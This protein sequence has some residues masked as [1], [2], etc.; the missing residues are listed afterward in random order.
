MSEMFKGCDHFKGST[1]G[2]WNVCNVTNMK[3]MF[4]GCTNFIGINEKMI[5]PHSHN[6]YLN[7][8]N[9]NNWNVCKVMNME[10][11]FKDCKNFTTSIYNWGHRFTRKGKT[12]ITIDDIDVNGNSV[13]NIL[14]KKQMLNIKDIFEGCPLKKYINTID[15][16]SDDTLDTTNTRIK[17]SFKKIP[18]QFRKAYTDKE[19]LTFIGNSRLNYNTDQKIDGKYI[20][21]KVIREDI[22]NVNKLYSLDYWIKKMKNEPDCIG[23][24]CPTDKDIIINSKEKSLQIFGVLIMATKNKKVV[25]DLEDNTNSDNEKDTFIRNVTYYLTNPKLI[26]KKTHSFTLNYT[27]TNINNQP[28]EPMSSIKTFTNKKSIIDPF[29]ELYLDLDYWI[30]KPVLNN[31]INTIS[32]I[33][34]SIISNNLGNIP[35]KYSINNNIENP[36]LEIILNNPKKKLTLYE[37]KDDLVSYTT[38]K[39]LNNN[40]FISSFFKDPSGVYYASVIFQ[41]NKGYS[42]FYLTFS[43]NNSDIQKIFQNNMLNTNIDTTKSISIDNDLF[44]VSMDHTKKIYIHGD[45]INIL[46]SDKLETIPLTDYKLIK[47]NNIK[48]ICISND[49]LVYIFITNNKLYYSYNNS[50]VITVEKDFIFIDIDIFL[51]ENNNKKAYVVTRHKTEKLFKLYILDISTENIKINYIPSIKFN[52]SFN[53]ILFMNTDTM[54]IVYS[55]NNNKYIKK[56]NIKNAIANYIT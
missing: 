21:Y 26:Q 25:D 13:S 24:M 17:E 29:Y 28:S 52:K 31:E 11:M 54:G 9:I 30:D 16:E 4:S 27:S 32:N 42:Q 55:E 34:F 22:I 44:N 20:Y 41:T 48:K 18:P 40:L 6:Y 5:H 38:D 37:I 50:N 33:P 56:S 1:I 19:F 35:F 7:H 53:K 45:K 14:N 46:K 15:N 8:Y 23:F 47:S 51:D 10:K 12:C 2:K 43:G 36:T 39:T 49:G 3:E